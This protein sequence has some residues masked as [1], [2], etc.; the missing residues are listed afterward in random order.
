MNKLVRVTRVLATVGLVVFTTALALAEEAREFK[1][2]KQPS[3]TAASKTPSVGVGILR[4][5]VSI[6]RFDISLPLRLMTPKPVPPVGYRGGLIRDPGPINSSAGGGQDIDPVVQGSLGN[7]LDGAT[8]IPAPVVS[9][10]GLPN[11]SGV[12]PPDPV[13]DVGPNHYVAMSNLS[14]EIYDKSGNSVFGPAANNTLWSGFG[15]DCES[16]NAGDPIV[17]YDQFHDRWILS[18]FTSPNSGPP[19]YNCVAISQTPDPTG[20]YYR[21][22]ISTGNAFPDYPKYGI[23]HDAIYISTREFT[24]N[25]FSGIGAY[26][27][28][29]NAFMA[30]NPSAQVI[31]FVVPP[32]AT[33]FNTGDGLLPADIDGNVLPPAGSPQYFV[34]SM[35]D[36]GPKNAP[37]DALTLWKF[38]ADFT[39]PANSS[40]MLTDTLPIAAYDTIFDDCSGR[41]CIPQKD[42]SNGLDIQSYRQRPLFR[43]AYRNF[44]S[45]ESLVTNQSVE[46]A[47]APS[48]GGIRWWEIRSPASNPVIFQEGT[49]AP[50][51]SDGIHRWM[52]STAM[53]AEGNIALAYSASSATIYPGL[54][55]TGRLV[56]DPLGQMTQGEGVIVEGTGSQT[57]ANRWGDYSS[58]NIDPVDDCT[59]W[60]VSEYVPVTS[61]RDWQLRIGAFKFN[62]C[63]DPG[64][65]LSTLQPG[66][67]V[68]T[69]SN[70]SSVAYP[71]Q[72]GAISNFDSPVT[73]VTTGLPAG[74]SESYSLNPVTPLPGATTLTLGNFS[75]V[76]PGIYPFSVDGS[77]TGAANKSLNLELSVFDSAPTNLQLIAPADGAVNQDILPALQWSADG[78]ETFDVVVATDPALNNVVYSATV[79][80]NSV[81]VNVDLDTDTVYYWAVSPANACGAAASPVHSFTTQPAPG[82]CGTGT[83][84]VNHFS[85]D[86]EAG[87][88]GWSS[89]GSGDTWAQSTAQVHSGSFSWHADDPPSPSD[90]QLVTPAVILPVGQSPLTLQF[91]NRQTLESR[92]SGGCWDGGLLEISTDSGASWTPVSTD[93]LLTDP[94]DGA[95]QGLGGLEGWCGDPQDWLKSVVDLDPWAGQTV[96]F[97]FRLG[98]DGSVSREGW[99]LD[100]VTVQGCTAV[101]DLIFKHGF[102]L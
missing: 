43:L 79:T 14:F 102:E 54:R 26:A 64:F 55:Y 98:S 41:D 39:T 51:L 38:V 28:E 65:Y 1:E 101:T 17:L 48:I 78:A 92:S 91:W 42:T 100:D 31:S 67:S 94:Y 24:N 33:P 70:G 29:I 63:G 46:A 53:D 81:A 93:K 35:D 5:D 88:T 86:F 32:G 2:V 84:A 71:I 20:A 72:V 27:L 18:Q 21:W 3:A 85:E 11:L 76:T 96:Q 57:G 49:F 58:L 59:F 95:V 10:D 25:S 47:S 97:R 90:Q 8:R 30:G 23:W 69:T 45:H 52:G 89:G 75:G 22:A 40:F 16:D 12:A 62:E 15:G 73:L 36:G 80:G 34:G 9:F 7:A 74:V 87:A 77:A 19:F 4:T 60:F 83:A 37:A 82:D 61:S 50:G 99:Y 13:G 66:A 68:C 56:S 44:G 6:E